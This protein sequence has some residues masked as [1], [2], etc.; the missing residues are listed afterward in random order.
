MECPQHKEPIKAFCRTCQKLVCI[1]CITRSHSNHPAQMIVDIIDNYKQQLK[2]G[3]QPVKQQITVVMD[4]IKELD[5]CDEA[6]AHQG[7]AIEQQIHSQALEVRNAVDQ[8]ERE[9]I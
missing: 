1:A 7:E 5:S 3:T 2:E 9:L 6:I 4:A 8:T